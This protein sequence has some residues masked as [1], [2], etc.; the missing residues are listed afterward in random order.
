MWFDSW[1]DL[2]RILVVGSA[3]YASLVLV[4]SALALVTNGTIS[5]IT[6]EKYGDGSALAGVRGVSA[7]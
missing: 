7:R 6:S 3:G 5:V 1:G 4:Q 2:L